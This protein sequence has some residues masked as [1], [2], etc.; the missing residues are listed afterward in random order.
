MSSTSIRIVRSFGE[1]TTLQRDWNTLFA[2]STSASPFL[3]YDWLRQWLELYGPEYTCLQNGLRVLL[4]RQGGELVGA[5]PLYVRRS[6]H[7][8]AGPRSV[9][10]LGTGEAESEETCPEYLD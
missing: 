8:F 1:F 3:H 2:A 9:R 7:A 5:L 4:F 10:F 6:D